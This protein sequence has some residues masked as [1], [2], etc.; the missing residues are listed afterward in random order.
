MLT[1]NFREP[2]TH[3][4]ARVAAS[5]IARRHGTLRIREVARIIGT[6][7]RS[8]ER[9]FDTNIGV[10][11]KT[12]SRLMRFHSYLRGESD[13]YFDDSHRI[14]DFHEFSGVTPSQ[15][16]SEQ[17]AMNDAFVGNVQD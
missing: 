14:R 4:T 1:R 12:Y 10:T 11:A 16:R 9:A 15:W 3:R 6:T 17:N 13:G 8:L 7:E 2:A 5:L